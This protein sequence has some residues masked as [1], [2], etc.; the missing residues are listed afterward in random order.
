MQHR[1][2]Y[3]Q[4]VT[5]TQATLGK[6]EESLEEVIALEMQ[7]IGQDSD[8]TID[9]ESFHLEEEGPM[10]VVIIVDPII[11]HATLSTAAMVVATIKVKV[12][13]HLKAIEVEQCPPEDLSSM[14]MEAGQHLL[15][16][17]EVMG[18]SPI[19]ISLL[20]GVPSPT[21][22][23]G[24]LESAEMDTMLVGNGVEAE[25][26]V[27]MDAGKVLE[28]VMLAERRAATGVHTI[29][30]LTKRATTMKAN[31]FDYDPNYDGYYGEEAKE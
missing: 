19:T 20:E 29:M 23:P 6:L 25:H 9:L 7:A 10:S 21:T 5:V 2:H 11:S 17:L 24:K 3:I 18:L 4:V 28:V 27:V 26:K 8:L 30:I 22:M 1:G 14:A 13:A 15:V 16:G 12:K 31:E